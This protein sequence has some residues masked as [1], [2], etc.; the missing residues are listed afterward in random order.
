MIF[1]QLSAVQADDDARTFQLRR[2]YLGLHLDAL[3]SGGTRTA[4]EYDRPALHELRRRRGRI[5]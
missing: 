2:R 4:L 1:E 5:S 3:A